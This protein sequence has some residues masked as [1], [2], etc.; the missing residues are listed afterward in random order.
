[1]PEVEGGVAFPADYVEDTFEDHSEDSVDDARAHHA[2]FTVALLGQ[3]EH[4]DVALNAK[5]AEGRVEEAKPLAVVVL[6]EIEDDADVGTDGDHLENKGG[7]WAT[8]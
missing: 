7:G 2:P 3:G 4:S 5:F 8:S 6:F 1:M